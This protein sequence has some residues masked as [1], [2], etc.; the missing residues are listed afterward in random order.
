MSP[1]PQPQQ[2]VTQ[3]QAAPVEDVVDATK[4]ARERKLQRSADS[5]DKPVKKQPK[6]D[7]NQ[8]FAESYEKIAKE[9]GITY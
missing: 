3:E 2:Q 6:F 5:S 4:Q 9:A 7:E 8:F 1:R